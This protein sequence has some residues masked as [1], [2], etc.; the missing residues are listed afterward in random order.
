MGL[1]IR[2]ENGVRVHALLL[3]TSD[4]KMRVAIASDGDT[5]ELLRLGDSWETERGEAVE[6]EALVQIPGVD[7]SNF[8]AAMRPRAMAAGAS[9]REF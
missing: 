1:I 5:I 7:G 2:Y 4:Q 6:I 3:A 8:W 9:F